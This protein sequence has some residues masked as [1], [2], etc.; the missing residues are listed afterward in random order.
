MVMAFILP[1]QNASCGDARLHAAVALLAVVVCGKSTKIADRLLHPTKPCGFARA[2]GVICRITNYDKP[3]FS[4]LFTIPLTKNTGRRGR[5]TKTKYVEFP[6]WK[7][8][9]ENARQ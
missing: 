3:L 2:S 4:V 9:K 7:D 5:A 6:G 1:L 8:D